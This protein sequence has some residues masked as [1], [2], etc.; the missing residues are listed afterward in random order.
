MVCVNEKIF[1]DYDTIY[2]VEKVMKN[3]INGNIFENN[4]FSH[5]FK[6]LINHPSTTCKMKM[7]I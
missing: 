2:N 7:F 6:L 5:F 3:A 4:Q 1:I